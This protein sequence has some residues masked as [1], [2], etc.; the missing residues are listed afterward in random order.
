MVEDSGYIQND[1]FIFIIFQKFFDEQAVQYNVSVL[2]S[3]L[4]QYDNE[5]FNSMLAIK[6]LSEKTREIPPCM[7]LC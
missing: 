1:M 2:Y 5:F 4:T 6:L 3:N 7:F